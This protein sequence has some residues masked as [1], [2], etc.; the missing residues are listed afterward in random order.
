MPT[1][2][3]SLAIAGAADR[4]G[5]EAIVPYARWKSHVPE[6]VHHRSS[7][8]LE[9]FV[10]AAAVA[11]CTQHSTIFA[12]CHVPVFHPL[13][14]AKQA[15]TV[16]QIAG[17]R[18]ALNV[19]AGW[20]GGEFEMFGFNLSGHESRYAQAT[21]WIELVKRAW[22]EPDAFSHHGEFYDARASVSRPNHNRRRGR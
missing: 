6:D 22:S 15:A 8:V 18:F 4:A 13:L 9:C 12:T 5:F 16:D 10:W 17:G 19:V 1:W 14:A 7:Q 21:E 2:A 3:N 20:Y 11:A